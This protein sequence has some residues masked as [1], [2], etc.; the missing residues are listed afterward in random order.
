MDTFFRIKV[1]CLRGDPELR[2]NAYMIS[3]LLTHEL[4]MRFT[5]LLRWVSTMD[6]LSVVH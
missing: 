5:A 2:G 1:D 4:H 3:Y 6:I